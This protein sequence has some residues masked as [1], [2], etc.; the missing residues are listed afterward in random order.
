MCHHN[1]FL[2]YGSIV[3][4]SQKKWEIITHASILTSLIVACLFGIAGYSTFKA[5]SQGLFYYSMTTSC[6]HATY[7]N[8]DSCSKVSNVKI[9]PIEWTT[10]KKLLN[11]KASRFWD[12]I[13]FSK[14]PCISF[15]ISIRWSA[16]KLLLGRRSDE[17]EPNSFQRPD[18]PH[19][20]DRVLCDQ[21]SGG[22]FHSRPRSCRA[23]IPKTPLHHHFVHCDNH[24][25]DFHGNGLFGSSFG[26]ERTCHVTL[27]TVTIRNT[28]IYTGCFGGSTFGL[29][30]TGFVLS[31]FRGG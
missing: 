20:P 7:Q 4:A 25:L 11:S 8:F 15:N 2:I 22:K 3:D 12:L 16:G 23:H 27:K 21:R 9:I 31:P 13:I 5:Y 18:P 1:T 19:L 6:F 17:R 10:F 28:K 30:F 14:T 29:R 26:V 24:L